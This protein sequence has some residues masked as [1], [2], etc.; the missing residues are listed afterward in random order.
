MM[1]SYEV[2]DVLAG[3]L[4][5]GCVQPHIQSFAEHLIGRGY[6]RLSTREYLQAGAHLGRWM[7]IRGIAPQKLTDAVLSSFARHRCECPRSCRRGRSPSRHYVAR[8]RRFVEHLRLQGVVPSAPPTSTQPVPAPLAGFRE[9]MLR[10]R[11]VTV[12]TINRYEF[13]VGKMLPAL[14]EDPASYEAA[15]IRRVFLAQAQGVGRAYAKCFVSALRAFLRFLAVE[16]RCR[17]YLDRA[18]PTIPEWRLSALPRY[19][20]P[21]E[22]ERVIASCDLGKP[23][24]VRDRAVLLLLARLG[25]RAGDI[26]AMKLDDLDWKAGTV[27]VRAKGRKEVRLPLPQDVGD[28]ILDYVARARP[29]TEIA[30][31]F[32]CVNAPVR[33]FPTTVTVSDIV[34]LA[35]RRAG[36]TNPPSRG[37]HLLRHSAATA[38]LRAGASLDAIATVLRHES[39]DTTAHYAKVDV[40]LLRRVAQPWPEVPQC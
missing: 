9:W 26:M 10:H 12:W 24:G 17:P 23:C 6:A 33:P 5:A 20:E 18:V 1:Q 25:L 4:P 28:A 15:L 39:T 40:A 3:L 22:V 32:L 31:V 7:D 35:L 36:I 34:R 11:G 2:A 37:A 14:G 8:A 29:A 38:M 30:R 21:G 19:I 13:L 27:R 16:G